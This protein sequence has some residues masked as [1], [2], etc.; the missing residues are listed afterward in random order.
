MDEHRA[1]EA[2]RLLNSIELKVLRV[3][4]GAPNTCS[5]SGLKHSLHFERHALVQVKFQDMFE[6]DKAVLM[7]Q[8]GTENMKKAVDRLL[9]V[10]DSGVEDSLAR[11]LLKELYEAGA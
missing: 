9:A 10:I 6:V 8:K 5:F 11:G 3:K 1:D 7:K 2:V 4:P